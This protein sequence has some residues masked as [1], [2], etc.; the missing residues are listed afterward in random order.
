M[1]SDYLKMIEKYNI[2]RAWPDPGKAALLVIDMQRYFVQIAEPILENVRSIHNACRLRG[3]RVVFTRHGHRDI[4]RDGGMLAE[5]WGDYIQYGAPEWELLEDLSPLDGETVIDKDRY[6]AF[7]G[8]GLDERLRAQ[9]I[10]Q[11]VITGVMTNCCCETTARDGF[12]RDYRIF[13]MADATATMDEELHVASLKTLAYGFAHILN[14]K[15]L[16]G[17]LGKGP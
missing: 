1:G 17:H 5:W 13:F 6:S 11:L 7:A 2:R 4:A 10:E 3:I 15:G 16:C 9:G 12:D 14:T 8:T